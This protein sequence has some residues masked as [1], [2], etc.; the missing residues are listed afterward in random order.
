MAALRRDIRQVSFHRMRFGSRTS[1]GPRWMRDMP[2]YDQ[3][4]VI[5]ALRKAIT[6]NSAVICFNVDGTANYGVPKPNLIQVWLDEIDDN[7]DSNGALQSYTF[8]F[9]YLNPFAADP[10]KKHLKTGATETLH[11]EKDEAGHVGAH[12]LV[13]V[14]DSSG[15]KAGLA[16]CILEQVQGL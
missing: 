14:M 2:H 16:K 5:D 7:R 3:K 8:R 4:D 10:G 15:E 6:A 12:L 11:I 1:E 9:S 13:G